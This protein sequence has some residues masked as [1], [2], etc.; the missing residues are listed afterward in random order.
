MSRPKA[1]DPERNPH[2]QLVSGCR[3]VVGALRAQGRLGDRELAGFLEALADR[4]A[5]HLAGFGEQELVADIFPDDR[6]GG[7]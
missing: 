7:G 5:M 3:V 1:F 2:G 6:A 4:S